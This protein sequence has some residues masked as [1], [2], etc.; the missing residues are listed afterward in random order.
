MY[1]LRRLKQQRAQCAHARAASCG[2]YIDTTDLR[3]CAVWRQGRRT[4]ATPAALR[5][6]LLPLRP[7]TT[8][9]INHSTDRERHI[10]NPQDFYTFFL[11]HSTKG[12]HI[13]KSSIFDTF[14]KKRQ[15]FFEHILL[16]HS[17]KYYSRKYTLTIEKI[18]IFAGF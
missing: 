16:P 14:Q 18:T 2:Q 7:Q 4:L 9:F 13:Q 6:S 10:K 5:P 8:C 12:R 15:V 17:S 1:R 3:A 11:F